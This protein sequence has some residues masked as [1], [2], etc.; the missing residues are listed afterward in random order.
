MATLPENGPQWWDREV[1]D[2]GTPIRADVRQAARQLWPDARNRVRSVLGDDGNAAE[3]MEATVLHI[4][5]HLD[6]SN[7]SPFGENVP[8]LLSLHFCQELR[9]RAAKLGRIKPVG[10]TADL[11]ERATVPAWVDDVNRRI[12]FQKLLPYL[13]DRSCTIVGMRTL[14]H[15]WKEIGEKL[16]ISPSTARNGFWQEVHE[17]LSKVQR[18]NGPNG[19]GNGQGER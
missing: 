5:H 15:D 13:S 7:A 2:Q 9:R 10:A 11:E 18:K 8:S 16:G 3:L 14:G 6:R 1:D 4:S 17:A 12:D 19:K